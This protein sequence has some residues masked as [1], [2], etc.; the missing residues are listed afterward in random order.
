MEEFVRYGVRPR[1]T[2]FHAEDQPLELGATNHGGVPAHS[3][4]RKVMFEDFVRQA[5]EC[6][7][8]TP[9]VLAVFP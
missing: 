9:D 3:P 1:R 4:L 2:A 6:K 8:C 5:T 7:G